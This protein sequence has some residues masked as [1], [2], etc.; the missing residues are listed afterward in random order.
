VANISN[1][2]S[3]LGVP[4][5]EQLS[6]LEK[7]VPGL[8]SRDGPIAGANEKYRRGKTQELPGLDPGGLCAAHWNA[9]DNGFDVGGFNTRGFKIGGWLMIKEDGR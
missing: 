2:Q 1:G 6:W 7:D 9:G 3:A 4:G 8:G 5:D